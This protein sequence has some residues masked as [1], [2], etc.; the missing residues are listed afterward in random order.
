VIAAPPVKPGAVNS[1]DTE[2][3]PG[4]T[5]VMNGAL[6]V[7]GS[8]VKFRDTLVAAQNVELPAWSAWIVQV[9]V[10]LMVTLPLLVIVH[11]DVVA[12][13]KLTV[14]PEVDDAVSE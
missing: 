12:L 6:G 14:R 3:F 8:T 13:V 1:S 11:T 5:D 10:V 4:V 2:V 9:P 7:V